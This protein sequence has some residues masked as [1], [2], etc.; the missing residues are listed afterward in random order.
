MKF[1]QVSCGFAATAPRGVLQVSRIIR[2]VCFFQ[3][4]PDSITMALLAYVVSVHADFRPS[5]EPSRGYGVPTEYP[6]AEVPAAE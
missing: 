2:F 3:Q 6:F 1:A 5:D 4:T